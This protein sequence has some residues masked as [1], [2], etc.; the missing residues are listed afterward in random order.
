MGI[1]RYADQTSSTPRRYI[2]MMKQAGR[3]RFR[4]EYLEIVDPGSMRPVGEITGPVRIAGAVW[5]GETRL[6]DNV[7]Q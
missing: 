4:I 3:S 5:L 6:I 1:K 7:L 2:E